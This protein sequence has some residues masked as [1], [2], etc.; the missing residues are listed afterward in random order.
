MRR[1]TPM[2]HVPDVR[3]AVHW[4]E[5][6]GFEIVST[7]EEDGTL[8]WAEVAFGDGRLMFNTGGQNSA[9]SRR[10]VDLYLH[11]EDVESIARRVR[12]LAEV[13]EELHDTFY[14]MREI[15][16]RDPHG[17]WLTFGQQSPGN[18]QTCASNEAGPAFSTG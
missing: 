11:V 12:E 18:A 16:V 13:V 9:A 3:R 15:I 2:I 6:I 17:F 4:Y 5:E 10:E 8:V 7:G 1:V 14:G